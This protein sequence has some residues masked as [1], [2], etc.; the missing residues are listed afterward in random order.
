MAVMDRQGFSLCGE[1][2]HASTTWSMRSCS[3]RKTYECAA[4]HMW[5]KR[6]AS[7]AIVIEDEE[8]PYDEGDGDAHNSTHLRA[9]VLLGLAQL[10]PIQ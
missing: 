2:T 7:H 4:S 9:A 1:D 5:G 8:E 3:G 10:F 6:R